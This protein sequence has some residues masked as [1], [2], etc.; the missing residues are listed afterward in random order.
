[1]VVVVVVVRA[2]VCMCVFRSQ[3]RSILSQ[4]QVFP[5]KSL[6]LMKVVRVKE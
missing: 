1:M 4:A 5:S 2:C 6:S 3:Q